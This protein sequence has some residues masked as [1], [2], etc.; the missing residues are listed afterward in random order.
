VLRLRTRLPVFLAARLKFL[1]VHYPLLVPFRALV[2]GYEEP[3]T[4]NEL[5]DMRL[6]MDSESEKHN[7]YGDTL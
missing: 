3:T 1:E 4:T 7:T 6:G 2:T 5:W